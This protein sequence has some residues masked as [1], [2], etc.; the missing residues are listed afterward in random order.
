MISQI[1][2]NLIQQAQRGDRQAFRQMVTHY[3]VFLYAVAFRYLG[4]AADA[5]DVVQEVFIKL[6]KNLSAYRSEVKMSTWL[7]RI[8]VNHCLD[9]KKKTSYQNERNQQSVETIV[10]HPDQSSPLDKLVQTEL[11]QLYQKAI[12]QLSDMQKM[13]Y[14]LR[15][16][17]DLPSAEVCQLVNVSED[18]VKSN[19]YHARKKIQAYIKEHYSE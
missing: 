18:Q 17:E 4:N 11:T 7:Y 5:E 19:L 9:M 1:D 10:N 2:L 12:D 16:V 3:Q 15:D 8:L 6:W 13:I 14:V